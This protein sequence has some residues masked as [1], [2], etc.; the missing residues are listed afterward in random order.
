ME[1]KETKKSNPLLLTQ[2]E[3]QA[4]FQMLGAPN[5]GYYVDSRR[6]IAIR[7]E[8]PN[9]VKYFYISTYAEIQIYPKNHRDLKTLISSR[10]E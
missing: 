8:D 5:R 9:D 6:G 1:E 3:L 2:E 4:S 10:Y 7:A